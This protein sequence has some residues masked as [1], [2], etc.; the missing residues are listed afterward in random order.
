MAYLRIAL[1]V[2]SVLAALALFGMLKHSFMYRAD[3]IAM[4]WIVLAGISLN[5]VYLAL[6]TPAQSTGL[7]GRFPRMFRLW[8]DAKETDL[9]RRSTPPAG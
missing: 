7:F 4:M 8:L 1:I 9:K 5:F 3:E 2:L 6:V